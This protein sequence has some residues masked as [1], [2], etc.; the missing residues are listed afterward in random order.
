MA[1]RSGPATAGADRAS[2]GAAEEV[3]QR[4]LVLR[5]T[6][7]VGVRARPAAQRAELAALFTGS[8][9]DAEQTTLEALARRPQPSDVKVL[10]GGADSFVT[11]SAARTSAATVTLRGRYRAWSQLAQ[12]VGGPTR[13]A[14]PSSVLDYQATVT[15][16]GGRWLVSSFAWAF[17]A[18][19]EP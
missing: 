12:I 15:N 7:V 6:V 1:V 14:T 9:L 3:L 18:G 8:A 4:A 17:H 5:Q 16:T 19:N 2:V 11:A 10:G 13:P